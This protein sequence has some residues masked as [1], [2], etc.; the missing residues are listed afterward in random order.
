MLLKGYLCITHSSQEL[1]RIG[2]D[3]NAFWEEFK[4][5]VDDQGLSQFDST[6]LKL[7]R[8]ELIRYPD[9]MVDDGYALSVSLG[10][11]VSP[12]RFRGK[13]LLPHY[14]VQVS[15]P[16]ALAARVFQACEVAPEPHSRGAPTEFL[17]ALPQSHWS[18]DP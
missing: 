16:E 1:K 2:H 12:M 14:S 18:L 13:E 3:L 17:N 7:D 11:P 10:Q 8:V 5:G 6:I 9:S 4:K 15:A